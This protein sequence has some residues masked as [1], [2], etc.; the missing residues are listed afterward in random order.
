MAAMIGYPSFIFGILKAQKHDIVNPIDILGPSTV[1]MRNNHKLYEGH[2]L[3]DVPF[4]KKKDNRKDNF[5]KPFS[6]PTEP[7][8]P[9]TNLPLR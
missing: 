4:E 1:E 9:E 5:L 6:S 8:L 7:L 3:R 2:H